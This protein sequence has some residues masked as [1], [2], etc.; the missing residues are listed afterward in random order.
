MCR[1][2]NKAL[3][4]YKPTAECAELAS[5]AGRSLK[6]NGID[7]YMLTVDDISA[8]KEPLTWVG[9]LDF[10]VSVGGD[11]TFMRV[12]KIA[13][14][15]SLILPYPCGRRNVYYERE[16][17]PI[18]KA[19]EIA[20]SGDFFLELLPIYSVYYEHAC[21]RFVNDVVVVSKDLG[22]VS[23]YT[24][25]FSSILTNGVMVFEGDGVI[26][27]TSGGSGGHNLS[28]KGPVIA[29]TVETLVITP[30]NPL[31]VGLTSIVVPLLAEVSVSAKNKALVYVDGDFF[32][33]IGE[34]RKISIPGDVSYVK[35]IRFK[36]SRNII[37]AVLEPRRHVF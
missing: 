22:K 20:L 34:G 6:S 30:M 35:I 31:Q 2:S 17:P 4:V 26:I 16:L 5:A 32:T 23:R 19:I 7:V 33:E 8:L 1:G 9:E 24:V 25:T 10:F 27:S 11:G 36:P 14:P 21:L 29:S 28:A 3:V 37:R 13:S 15:T 18:D 12:S